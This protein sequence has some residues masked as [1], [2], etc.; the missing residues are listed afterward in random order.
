MLA[1]LDRALFRG[2]RGC[3]MN[4]HIQDCVLTVLVIRWPWRATRRHNRSSVLYV[5]IKFLSRTPDHPAHQP[6]L[7]LLLTLQT[8]KWLTCVRVV[9]QINKLHHLDGLCSQ[10]SYT[11]ATYGSSFTWI[12]FWLTSR[13]QEERPKDGVPILTVMRHWWFGGCVSNGLFTVESVQLCCWI[14]SNDSNETP[15]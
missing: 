1:L 11:P 5:R 8:R 13:S 15:L 10:N 4:W 14:R 9:K 7:M 2:V 12:F 3:E 6:T